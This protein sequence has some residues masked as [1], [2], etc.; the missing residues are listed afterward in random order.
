MELGVP[1]AAKRG[2]QKGACVKHRGVD[3]CQRAHLLP[4][5]H[6]LSTWLKARAAP[7]SPPRPRGNAENLFEFAGGLSCQP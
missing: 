3:M 5:Y 4:A 6:T 2:K 7:T 1:H